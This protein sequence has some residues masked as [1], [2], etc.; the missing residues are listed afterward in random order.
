MQHGDIWRGLDQLAEKHGLTVSGLARLAGLDAT[1]F[2]KSK[3]ISKDGRPRWPSTESISRAL[4]AVGAE[5]GEF[6]T[7]V[8]GQYGRVTP[9]LR[10]DQAHETDAF[11]ASGQPNLHK[12]EQDRFPGVDVGEDIYVVE[13]SNDDASQFYRPGDRLVVSPSAGRR[14]GDRVI[15]KLRS[16]RLFL[17]ELGRET[18]SHIELSCLTDTPEMD[19]FDAA[20]IAWI[21][22]ILWVSQ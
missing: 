16:G 9:L 8:A 11:L 22:R 14:P 15:A 6:A 5:M 2:N 4:H 12:W 20:E 7:L 10:L 18:S 19:K 13:V 1:A 3:R 21:A 17:A